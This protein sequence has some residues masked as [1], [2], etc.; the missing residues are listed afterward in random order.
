MEK[1]A[2]A[3]GLT[4]GD[5]DGY[6]V[7]KVRRAYRWLGAEIR[8]LPAQDF[9]RG[10]LYL[11]W[12]AQSPRH[13]THSPTYRGRSTDLPAGGVRG[14]SRGCAGRYRGWVPVSATLANR[15]LAVFHPSTRDHASPCPAP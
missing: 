2:V 6:V 4:R 5:E 9:L 14:R 11:V 7:Q 3:E 15:S 1:A 13:L 10:H 12:I 8:T